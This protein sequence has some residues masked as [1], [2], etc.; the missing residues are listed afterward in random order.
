MVFK[1]FLSWKMTIFWWSTTMR[2][3]LT[4]ILKLS[5]LLNCKKTLFIGGHKKI[6]TT[7]YV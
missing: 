7:F 4:M 2:L 6:I 3:T 1:A 5:F